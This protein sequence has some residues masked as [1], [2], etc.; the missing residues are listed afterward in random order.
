[1]TA[2]L[3]VAPI[4]SMIQRNWESPGDSSPL[5]RQLTTPR[6]ESLPLVNWQH[7]LD[8]VALRTAWDRDALSVFFGCRTPVYNNHAHIDPGGFDFTALGRAMVVD[9][10]RFC[11]REDADRRLFKSARWHNMLTIGDRDPFAYKNSWN[12]G[13]QRAGGI[14]GVWQGGG[15]LAS[16]C[17]HRNYASA[18][19][20][21]ALAL[22]EG[23]CLVVLDA[24]DGLSAT[25]SVQRWFH[26][27]TTAVTWQADARR[28]VAIYDGKT[29]LT[30]A[31]ASLAGS[32]VGTL[33]P[34][35]V[36]ERMDNSHPSTRLRLEDATGSARRCYAAVLIPSRAAEPAPRIEGLEMADRPE[37]IRCSF[38]L[39]GQAFALTWSD[40]TIALARE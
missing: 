40:K 13:P 22:V 27:D 2:Y 37:G 15:L 39:D 29:I 33:E 30:L 26:L 19:H 7:G 1:M 3:G 18:V 5:L 35:R 8:Q 11:Y 6:V 38:R 32:E 25:D 36:S 4:R 20:R 34:G 14:T 23:R 21:R 28:A 31:S 10:G 12:Y 17:L 24:V 9:P 16:A